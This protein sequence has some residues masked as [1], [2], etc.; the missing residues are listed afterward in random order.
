MSFEL[1][2]AGY[3]LERYAEEEK[4]DILEDGRRLMEKM[5]HLGNIEEEDEDEM[6]EECEEYNEGHMIM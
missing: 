6:S 5:G 4:K 3:G 2:R 1:E